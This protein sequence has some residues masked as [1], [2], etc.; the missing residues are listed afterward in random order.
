[1]SL[2]VEEGSEPVEERP[3]HVDDTPELRIP[4]VFLGFPLA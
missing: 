1:V 2:A 4:L 3:E